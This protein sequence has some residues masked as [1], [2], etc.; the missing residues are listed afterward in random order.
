MHRSVAPKADSK[1]NP[2][3]WALGTLLFARHLLSYKHD[4]LCVL[5]SVREHK[6]YATRSVVHELCLSL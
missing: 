1:L 6:N 3:G 2:F 5:W 4:R